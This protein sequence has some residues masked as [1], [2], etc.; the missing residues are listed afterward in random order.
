MEISHQHKPD[1]H[2]KK[3]K[4]YVFEFFMLFL[5]VA[6][7]FY[8]DYQ[9]EQF[10]DRHKEQEYMQSMAA[11][12]QQDLTNLN[13]AMSE[14]SSFKSGLDSL[15]AYCSSGNLTDSVQRNLYD[16]NLRY[17]RLV[18]ITFSDRTSSQLKYSGSMRLIRKKQ[19]ADSILNYWQQIDYFNYVA[20]RQENF[21]IKARELSFKIFDYRIYD[22]DYGF[23]KNHLRNDR[24]HLF[25]TD[26]ALL[27]EYANFVLSGRTSLYI[28][29]Y[30]AIVKL[31]SRAQNLVD[32]L[33]REYPSE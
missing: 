22:L 27:N 10:A 6:A 18:P 26:R 32:Q 20:P 29:Y 25:S 28:Y 21:R 30:P 33:K 7:G 8:S 14:L 24:P 12:V 16:L 23:L 19:V 13:S 5:A 1:V 2:V 11:D 17:L 31:Q 15:A 4:E 3:L 9:R